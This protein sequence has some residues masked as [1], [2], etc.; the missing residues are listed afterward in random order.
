[1]TQTQIGYAMIA[2]ATILYFA[3]L[4]FTAG[5][6]WRAKQAIAVAMRENHDCAQIACPRCRTG[7]LLYE[8]GDNATV[9]VKCST[10]DCMG[11]AP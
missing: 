10:P 7:N 5:T 4:F 9:D 8:R 3:A 11:L 1:M 2:A 6:P